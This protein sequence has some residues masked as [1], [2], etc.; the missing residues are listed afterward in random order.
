[1]DLTREAAAILW[2]EARIA[3][4]EARAAWLAA[5]CAHGPELTE[6]RRAGFDAD[7]AYRAYLAAREGKVTA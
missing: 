3:E 4:S 7:A 6:Y 1:M 5:G 2:A